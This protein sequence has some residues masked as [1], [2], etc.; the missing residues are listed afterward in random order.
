MSSKPNDETIVSKA[1]VERYPVLSQRMEINDNLRANL[2]ALELI[3]LSSTFAL[4]AHR[5]AFFNI[6]QFSCSARCFVSLNPNG[7]PHV[8][9]HSST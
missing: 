4:L 3:I 7:F 8:L 5:T 9:V 2:R 6:I 1:K